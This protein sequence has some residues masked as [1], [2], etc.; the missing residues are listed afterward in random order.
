MTKVLRLFTEKKPGFDLEARHLLADLRDHLGLSD[1]SELRLLNR[2]DIA[3]L[4]REDFIRARDL[5]F[6]EPN[7]DWVYEETF[8]LAPGWQAFAKEPL[9]GQYDQR[10][11]SAALCAQLL[12]QGERPAVAAAL[13][14]ALPG[15]AGAGDVEKIQKHLV[16]PLE[17]RLASMEKPD[18][19]DLP[20]SRPEDIPALE[21]F[22]ICP[23]PRLSEYLSR[24]RLAMNA[25][26]LFFCRD[27]FRDTERRDPTLT[28]LRVIDT[29]W[30]DH[31]RHTTFNTRLDRIEIEP[32]P[33]NACVREAFELY[34]AARGE[35][36]QKQPDAR[37]VTLMDMATV[38]ARTLKKRGLL[39]DLDE[40]Q[41]VNACSFEIPADVSGETQPWLIQFKNETHNHPT[42]IEPF[43]GAATCL[44]GAI[45]DPLSGRAYVYQAMRL[46]GCG[47]PR[48]PLEQTLPG[49]LSQRAITVGAARGYSSYG[50][51]IG[52]ATGQVTELY[53]PGYVAKRMEIGA[54]VGAC[55]K[56][57]VVRSLPEPGDIILLV[58]GRTG[59]DGCGGATGSSKAH[60]LSSIDL[61]GAEVQKGNPPT[62]RKIQRL[63]RNPQV[64]RMIR[65]CNDFGAGG[66]SV[67]IGEL[68]PGLVVDLDRIPKKYEGLDGTE[69][70]ISESQERMA[71]VVSP[72]DA[73][74][75]IREAYSENLEA[76]PIAYVSE[77][78]R[79]I[80]RWRG[81]TIVNISRAFLDT[82]G[83]TQHAQA[84]IASVDPSG[85]YRLRLP[86]ECLDKP[87]REAW[88]SNLGRLPVCSQ[89]GLSERFDSTVGGHTVH[90]PFSGIRQMT[91]AEAM[92]A[93]IP[94]YGGTT[95]TATAMSFGFIPGLASWSP[96]H[97]G[98]FAVTEALSKL[99]AVGAHP[100]RAR[101]SMQEYYEVLKD[102]PLKWGKPAAALLGALSAQLNLGVPAI[103]GKDSMS[104]TFQY[105]YA[106]G[107]DDA[108]PDA[109]R[110]AE[111]R[112][113][114]TR[115]AEIHVPP[116]LVCFAVCATQASHAVSADFKQ[117]GSFAVFLPLPVDSASHL[118]V[119]A[120][121]K[122]LYERIYALCQAGRV[123]A[124]SVVREGGLAAAVTRMCL[125]N[126][127][128]LAF[129]TV[130]DFQTL[131]APLSSSLVVELNGS[132]D[133][134]ELLDGLDYTLLGRTLAHPF[135]TFNR[136]TPA[137][138][139]GGGAGD[140]AVSLEEA[141][142]AWIRPLEK[143]FPTRPSAEPSVKSPLTPSVPLHH[144]RFQRSSPVSA[145]LAHP[146][147]FIPVFPGI[148]CELETAAAFESAG[149]VCDVF[150]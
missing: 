138:S 19:L 120:R 45:R 123:L 35:V 30:S 98:A 135:I 146:R 94:V 81:K 86:E 144:E 34:Q 1:L 90:M 40:S 36:L 6:S 57:S 110:A 73:E 91:P 111:T 62:E 51:Q 137:S 125:G 8:P 107:G 14:V 139:T 99:A 48:T 28:E 76:T 55:P 122:A 105:Q 32:G 80:M 63:F 104:G 103:G 79:L 4:S 24:Y 67:A 21:G 74:N 121:V 68:A 147:V 149:A 148:N 50:N 61:C 130:P 93:K 75:F 13:V 71:V 17:S 118:P 42:E 23:D 3:G 145:H 142:Q 39:D 52:L 95:D 117:P 59:R 141:A 88:L 44:G 136:I 27:Y 78:P 102:D 56:S 116:T 77:N 82:G 31:C 87:L 131:F 72:G 83:V 89:K 113:T 5:I 64:S 26:D 25:S 132:G 106:S 33:L 37:P 128:G 22:I 20:F 126:Q 92:I 41:E 127:I 140:P 43:G 114:E 143:I 46:T 49:K 108:P 115:T 119:W 133:P 150:V 9:P 16:N 47:D 29:Y 66:V 85:D 97:G 101:L 54:V 15:G 124:A 109:G 134:H 38:G 12:T 70:A 10:S 7:T 58:G 53:D 2:Y 129:D 11:D 100:L 84:R 60:D 65:R 96:F 18:A 69:L 112:P